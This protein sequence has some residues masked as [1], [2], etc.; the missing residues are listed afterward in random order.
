MHRS[1]G[2]IFHIKDKIRLTYIYDGHVHLMLSSCCFHLVLL[3]H[4]RAKEYILKVGD[5][6]NRKRTNV[7]NGKTFVALNLNSL[8]M[9][10]DSMKYKHH[11]P[12]VPS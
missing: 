2:A 7:I 1:Q 3:Q 8:D 11:F 12:Y 6:N 4:E 5:C 10:Y 9:K